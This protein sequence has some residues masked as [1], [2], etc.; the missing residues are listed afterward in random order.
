VKRKPLCGTHQGAKVCLEE[1]VCI[2]VLKKTS[3]ELHSQDSSYSV[4]DSGHRDGT[5]G[6]QRLHRVDEFHVVVGHHHLL[7]QTKDISSWGLQSRGYSGPKRTQIPQTSNPT[8]AE[9][10]VRGLYHVNA[11][12]DSKPDRVR[13]VR[14]PRSCNAVDSAPVRDDEP[15]EP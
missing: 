8:S 5:G 12:I 15:S 11:R 14:T 13:I 2:R 7:S 3:L 4:V 10:G 9:S 6:Y 1:V